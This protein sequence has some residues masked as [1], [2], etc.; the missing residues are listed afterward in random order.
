MIS[1]VNI[2]GK[3]RI[4][5]ASSVFA[6]P[7]TKWNLNDVVITS[8]QTGFLWNCYQTGTYNI[9]LH[10]IL[11]EGAASAFIYNSGA[12]SGSVFNINV[13]G[14]NGIPG[15][16][17]FNNNGA[18]GSSTWNIYV[19]D[20]SNIVS[21]TPAFSNTTSQTA[22]VNWNNPDGTLPVDVTKIA[23]TNRGF[24]A[25][26]NNSSLSMANGTYPGAG[27]PTI[28]D[29]TNLVFP[30][31]PGTVTGISGTSGTYTPAKY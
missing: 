8:G 24:W 17:L 27:S 19:H 22:T 5:S 1:E 25:T 15:A 29:G 26:P 4:G 2:G 31:A 30:T 18:T 10:N 12:G 7:T 11:N 6:A 23:K 9:S 21:S 20:V 3:H 13:D 14:M 28:S 16:Q